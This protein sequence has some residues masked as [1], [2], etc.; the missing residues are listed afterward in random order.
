MEMDKIDL[1]FLMQNWINEINLNYEQV[2]NPSVNLQLN[3]Q[4]EVKGIPMV[5][6][7]HP[8]Q[9]SKILVFTSR[10]NL[11]DDIQ[12]K[13]LN[14]EK[15]KRDKLFWNIKHSLIQLG[16]NFRIINPELQIPNTWEIN[17]QISIK[18][19]TFQIFIDTYN[20]IKNGVFLIQWKIQEILE[21]Q[22]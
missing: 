1:L 2:S 12:I 14:L 11:P 7:I 17:K 13:L 15:L 5:V 22:D 3:I 18:D 10:I 21:T 9:D 6:I 8:K 16:I 20:L 19:I 4:S